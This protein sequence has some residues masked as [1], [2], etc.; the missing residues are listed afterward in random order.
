MVGVSTLVYK[1]GLQVPV[2]P[3]GNMTPLTRSFLLVDIVVF[4]LLGTIQILK[5]S[6]A[7]WTFNQANNR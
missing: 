3:V 4:S 6:G 1:A 7:F 5:D 2:P